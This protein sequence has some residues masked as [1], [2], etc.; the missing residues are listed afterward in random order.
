MQLTADCNELGRR[1]A[2]RMWPFF[3]QRDVRVAAV[4]SLDGAVIDP[5]PH[6]AAIVGAAGAASAAGADDSVDVLLDRAAMHHAD[7]PT[8]YGAAWL[9][10]GRLW[11]TTS[12]LGGCADR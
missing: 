5:S 7:E 9:A 10:L 2:A 6:P 1:I 12:L 11:L 4:H 3:L 8:Y